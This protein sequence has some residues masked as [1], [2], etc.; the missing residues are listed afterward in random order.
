M[1]GDRERWDA[2]YTEGE[3]GDPEPDAFVLRALD[4]LGNLRP[5]TAL[6][7]AAGTGRHAL[8]LARRGWAVS[9]WDVSPVGLARL[10]RRAADE[11]LSIETVERDLV[12]EAP[13]VDRTFD[14]VLV[15]NFL[16]RGL[17]GRLRELV[18][19]G[20]HLVLTTYTEDRPGP[21]PALEHC[22]KRGEL[23]TAVPG[24]APLMQFEEGG[25]AGLVAA[26]R[27]LA[28]DQR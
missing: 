22:L 23:A 5:G 4:A 6:D 11:G 17:Y 15:S 25:R 21:R 9:A 20:G 1:S 26:R 24:F 19:I 28:S 10:A 16:D 8:E 3:H 14:L 27:R 13:P 18:A 12:G 2:R 7:V